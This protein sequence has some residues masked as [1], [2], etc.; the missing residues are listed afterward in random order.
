[1]LR[2]PCARPMGGGEETPSPSPPPPPIIE[3]AGGGR[4]VK[5]IE[6]GPCNGV[7]ALIPRKVPSKREPSA[8]P[9]FRAGAESL[10]LHKTQVGKKY[11][12]LMT[13]PTSFAR[14][15]KNQLP[16]DTCEV[17]ADPA[18]SSHKL[19]TF[20]T[21]S[22]NGNRRANLG[23]T[24]EN[25]LGP[26]ARNGRQTV[27]TLADTLRIP[28]VNTPGTVSGAL[29]AADSDKPIRIALTQELASD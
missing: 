22:C 29:D 4:G 12:T 17:P 14:E 16:S 13:M 8:E 7:R 9:P 15:L 5:I 19:T 6:A 1:M 23:R 20:S 2:T 10:E 26:R 28:V 24:C 3:L 11:Q 25:T 27:V 18:T 21:T